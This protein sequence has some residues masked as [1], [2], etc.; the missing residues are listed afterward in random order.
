M[1]GTGILSKRSKETSGI[2]LTRKGDHL[3]MSVYSGELTKKSVAESFFKLKNAFPNLSK[4]FFDVFS[5]RVKEHKFNND[6]LKNAVNHVIDNCIYPQ[7]TIAQI[8][9]YDKLV[10]IY[11][12][13]DISKMLN[14]NKKAFETY[15]SIRIGNNK[16]PMYAH[17]NDI[18][19][20]K[21]EKWK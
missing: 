14:E 15:Q 16:K 1:E 6:R 7:P 11:T 12:W 21:L 20:Y 9:S 4:V 13:H 10:K 17:V 8:I 18:E 3:E 19:T 5:D 2:C